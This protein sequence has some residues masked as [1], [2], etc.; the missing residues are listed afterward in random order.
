MTYDLSIPSQLMQ[1]LAPDIVLMVGAMALMLVAAWRPGSDRHQ[2][3][4]GYGSIVVLP[5]ALMLVAAWPPVSDRHQRL[6]GY[7]SIVV[8]LMT[9]AVVLWYGARGLSS[10]PGVIAVDGFRFAADTLFILAA[11]G[12][13]MLGM[14]YNGREGTWNASRMCSCSSR[15]RA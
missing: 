3:L 7:G 12:A 11:L 5:M 10:G 15:P 1:A 6:V 4:A 14:E 2:P 9:L 13:A 8:L